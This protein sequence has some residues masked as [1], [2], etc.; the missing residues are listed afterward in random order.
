MIKDLLTKDLF[1]LAQT[2][3]NK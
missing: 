2:Q 3:N 1:T